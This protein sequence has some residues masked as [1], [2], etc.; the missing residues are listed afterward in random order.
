MKVKK[1]YNDAKIPT[2]SHET[3][4]G[5]D[6]YANNIKKHYQIDTDESEYVSQNPNFPVFLKPNERVLIGTGIAGTFGKGYE[7][8]ARPRSGMALKNGITVL[9]SPG[10]IDESY[11]GEISIILINHSCTPYWI[12]KDDK[13]AQL[14]ICRVI[15]NEIIVVDDLGETERGDNG[16]GSTGKI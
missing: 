13:I 16:Y 5:M 7:I 1:L 3:D 12:A 14:V 9:N 8:Q 15:L 10:T 2:R 11:R 4:S 6:V